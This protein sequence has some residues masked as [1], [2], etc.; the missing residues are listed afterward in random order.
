MS[1]GTN[2]TVKRWVLWSGIALVLIACEYLGLTHREDTIP[3]SVWLRWGCGAL[4]IVLAIWLL[5]TRNEFATQANLFR[6][7]QLGEPALDRVMSAFEDRVST[8]GLPSAP[9]ASVLAV[10]ALISAALTAFTTLSIPALWAILDVSIALL[11]TIA[12]AR[13]QALRVRRFATLQVRD[14]NAVVPLREWLMISVAVLLPLCWVTIEPFPAIA[15]AAAGATVVALARRVASIPALLLGKDFAAERFVDDRLRQLRT[16][17][18]LSYAAAT[19]PFF[20]NFTD[21]TVHAM[22]RLAALLPADAVMIVIGLRLTNASRRPP[23]ESE[24][25]NWSIAAT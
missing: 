6:T 18:L 14:P 16:L 22:L 25:V 11:C 12:Y 24:L 23:S 1:S 8:E 4:M 3:A 20:I 21:V 9:I 2:A 19:V 13:L 17:E 5:W 7:I 10:L 15:V